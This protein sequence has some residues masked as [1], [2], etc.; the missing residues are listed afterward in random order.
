MRSQSSGARGWG[1][2]RGV[3]AHRAV[4]S[5]RVGDDRRRRRR[6]RHGLGDGLIAALTAATMEPHA[7]RQG[8]LALWL[9]GGLRLGVS[10]CVLKVLRGRL[11]GGKGAPPVHDA[12]PLV[13]AARLDR[14]VRCRVAWLFC[15]EASACVHHEQL[16]VV[17]HVVEDRPLARRGHPSVATYSPG[18]VL[19]TSHV[20][21]FRLASAAATYVMNA[22]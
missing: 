19:R 13:R 9:G 20:K 18:R 17:I 10:L 7:Q 8:R 21:N 3:G 14:A 11:G 5:L 16:H 1:P 6:G 22:N 15:V 12:R 4:A 2:L